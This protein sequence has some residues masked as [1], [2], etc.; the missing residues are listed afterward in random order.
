MRGVTRQATDARVH[1]RR[2]R[3]PEGVQGKT[4]P[5]DIADMLPLELK[6]E[7][8]RTIGD[9]SFDLENTINKD[10]SIPQWM[11]NWHLV[12]RAERTSRS[13]RHARRPA[14]S[15][16]HDLTEIFPPAIVTTPFECGSTLSK[17]QAST[18]HVRDESSQLHIERHRSA[19]SRVLHGVEPPRGAV[20]EVRHRAEY[21][22]RG[23]APVHLHRRPPHR[24]PRL[25]VVDNILAKLATRPAR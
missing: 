25:T 17:L 5:P 24:G 16:T 21:Q 19:R 22:P 8:W 2:R 6:V 14:T 23:G 20:P 18:T 3:R 11:Q 10:S 12:F 7:A 1:D 13:S 15:S 9:S 4:H